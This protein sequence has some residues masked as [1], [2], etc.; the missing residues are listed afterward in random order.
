[1]NRDGRGGKEPQGTIALG[2]ADV[3]R[4]LLRYKALYVIVMLASIGIGLGLCFYMD[5]KYRAICTLLPTQSKDSKLNRLDALASRFGLDSPIPGTNFADFLDPIANSKPFL[6]Q[7]SDFMAEKDG[8]TSRLYDYFQ[9]PEGKAKELDTLIYLKRVREMVKLQKKAN[10]VVE[11]TVTSDSPQMAAGIANRIGV[12]LNDF[13]QEYNLANTR[14]HLKYLSG[15]LA[16]AEASR[17]AS[18]ANLVRFLEAN[19]GIDPLTSPALF[20]RHAELRMETEIAN[21]KYMLLRNQYETSELNLSKKEPI[22]TILETA[23]KPYFKHS[24]RRVD[25]MVIHL[26]GGI[27]FA[28]LLHVIIVLWGPFIAIVRNGSRAA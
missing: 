8:K 19:R 7:L 22:L 23:S 14:D 21:Q 13:A 3:V 11:V 5:P 16:L 9:Y 1:M 25:M 12:M 2:L 18:N 6:F 17:K 27:I 10:G 4:S 26:A 15:Q 24:P 28:I 20:T